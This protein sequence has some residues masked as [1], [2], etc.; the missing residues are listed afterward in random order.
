[1]KRITFDRAAMVAGEPCCVV[2]G[3]H[4]RGFDCRGVVFIK[5]E[6]GHAWMEFHG[7]DANFRAGGHVFQAEGWDKV[8]FNLLPAGQLD[9]LATDPSLHI[10]AVNRGNVARGV[11]A[12]TVYNSLGGALV[13]SVRF[14]GLVSS[15]VVVPPILTRPEPLNVWI[16]TADLVEVLA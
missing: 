14:E 7:D 5:A 9:R 4:I 1:M 12:C 2:D 13:P 8:L 11:T 3:E 6:G 15:A 10:G 16:E